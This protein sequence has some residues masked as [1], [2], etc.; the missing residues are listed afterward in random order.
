VFVVAAGCSFDASYRSGQTTCS[1]GQCPSGLVCSAAHV[2]VTPGED[3]S[4]GSDAGSGV[5]S[6]AHVAALT[7]ADP[8]ALASGVASMGTTV[9]R[10]NTVAAS[11]AGGIMNGPDAVYA[12]AITASQSLQV[13]LAGSASLSAYVVATCESNPTCIDNM[14]AA[15]NGSPITA[16]PGSAGTYYVVVDSLLAAGSGTYTLTVTPE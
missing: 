7:C 11:C 14:A 13:T 12:I 2:C 3:A 4:L 15:A 5:G 8:G 16:S 1:D 9:G 6:D 10:D